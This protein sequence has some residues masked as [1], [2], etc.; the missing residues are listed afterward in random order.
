MTLSFVA[1]EGN[2]IRSA[3][4]CEVDAMDHELDSPGKRLRWAR[5]R[6]GID[7]VTMAR[8]EGLNDKTYRAYE[9]EQNGYAKRA[10]DFA[11]RL[12]VPTDWLLAGGP[13]P[14]TDPPFIAPETNAKLAPPM[15]GPGSTR[16]R[17]DVPVYGTALGASEV[18][19]GEAVEQTYLNTGEVIAYRRRPV[20]LD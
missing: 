5:E 2:I 8:L 19:D 10:P 3:A 14:T 20:I 1:G 17:R 9:N 11:R 16:M 12:N 18:I 4:S 15:E 7:A 13:I 6:A